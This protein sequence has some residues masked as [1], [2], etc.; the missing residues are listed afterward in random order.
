MSSPEYPVHPAVGD[1]TATRRRK[2][3]SDEVEDASGNRKERT[4]RLEFVP[5]YINFIPEI[6]ML[7]ASCIL[8]V[9]AV[10]GSNVLSVLL[11][12]VVLTYIFDYTNSR[13]L[14]LAAIWLTVLLVSLGVILTNSHTVSSSWISA[15]VV[16]DSVFLFFLIGIFATAM[17]LSLQTEVP[18][19]ALVSERLLLGLTPIVCLPLL[20][21]TAVAFFGSQLA[22]F[23]FSL[24]CCL[25][26]RTFYSLRKSALKTALHPVARKEEFINGRV[27]A[28]VFTAIILMVPMMLHSVSHP[29]NYLKGNHI[30]SLFTLI[31][32]PVLYL[33]LDP[34]KTM[35]FLHTNPFVEPENR[36]VEND[37]V[38]NLSE[39]RIVICGGS[40]FVALH[41]AIYRL[42]YGRFAHL[43]VTYGSGITA[44]LVC[45]AAY[46]ASVAVFIAVRLSRQADMRSSLWYVMFLCSITSSLSF[47]YALG[48]GGFAILQATCA[49]SA[50]LTY[51]IDPTRTTDYFL[52]AVTSS[53]FLIIWMHK[54][55]SFLQMDFKIYNGTRTVSLSMLSS[56][57][58]FLFVLQCVIYPVA[59]KA[60]GQ[61]SHFFLLLLQQ[62][63]L[64][65]AI[66]HMLYSQPESIYPWYCV[67]ATSLWGAYFTK[68]LWQNSRLG[69][70]E[71]AAL[72][73][74]YLG[75]FYLFS[76]VSTLPDKE[77]DLYI[78]E[79]GDHVLMGCHILSALMCSLVLQLYYERL[80]KKRRTKTTPAAVIYL[81]SAV[82][83]GFFSQ[84]SIVLSL[85]ELLT[86]DSDVGRG[87]LFGLTLIYI[88]GLCLPMNGL[89]P[90]SSFLKKVVS[91]LFFFGSV[92]ALVDPGGIDDDS[93]LEVGVYTPPF[94]SVYLGLISVGAWVMTLLGGIPILSES[95][96]LR[97]CWW[98]LVSLSCSM[99]FCGLFYPYP[100]F[101][102]FCLVTVVFTAISIYVDL[103]HFNVSAQDEES[104]S[105]WATYTT[106]LVATLL[107]LMSAQ[108][109]IPE[110]FDAH[111]H[112][113]VVMQ[114]QDA[115]LA[116]SVGVNLLTAGLLK[117]KL[118]ERP[119]MAPRD[120]ER[121][122]SIRDKLKGGT[123]FGLLGNVALIQVFV[124]LLV[125]KV[126]FGVQS[127]LL[128]VLMSPIFLLMNDDGFVF[129]NMN[130]PD[131]SMRYFA[132]FTSAVLSILYTVVTEDLFT[133]IKRSPTV[134]ML[135]GTVC[136]LTLAIACSIAFDLYEDPSSRRKHGGGE[137]THKIAA[138]IL[139]FFLSSTD[140]VRILVCVVL[141]GSSILC[142][143]DSIWY[144]KWIPEL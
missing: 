16:I 8:P 98:G 127:K 99:S 19:F 121:S 20:Y 36:D 51:C 119:V 9:L 120:R 140:S 64:L 110:E 132:P 22:C 88:G 130:D 6:S 68:T 92:M 106:C 58:Y 33:F 77:S 74:L 91:S 14:T 69:K 82:F 28:Y 57:I 49:I 15:L 134:F 21:S 123:H 48:F 46:T 103:I 26:H 3:Q 17:F 143:N 37:D 118:I 4:Y 136:A 90:S 7:F 62:V 116:L 13:K 53:L 60:T 85:V 76:M 133:L 72:A 87:R 107:T 144:S 135:Q 81:M 117:L 111:L 73:G 39:M 86:G 38:L 44:A 71:A 104:N 61:S 138:L 79:Y 137:H 101:V 93:S 40:Y 94:W 97:S 29:K 139:F 47:T 2:G 52:F 100:T 84:G 50:L 112:Y 1:G 43:F 32:V 34:P 78:H 95:G 55:F 63:I 131:H 56:Y 142:F 114:R 27:E 70:G 89:V 5:G 54:S 109:F 108:Y 30:L 25:L 45:L 66:E 113:E 125:L 126:D 31:C 83:V 128:P 59:R 80:Q 23:W 18:E 102:I 96:I 11:S 141:S 129:T 10:S 42:L 12:G 115:V 105:V 35:W 41:W 65:S 24:I 122:D 124:S 67:A 75:K